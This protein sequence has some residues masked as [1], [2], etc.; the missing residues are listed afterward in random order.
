[1]ASKLTAILVSFGLL[2][3]SSVSAATVNLTSSSVGDSAPPQLNQAT[4]QNGDFFVQRCCGDPIINNATEEYVTWTMD[5]AGAFTGVVESINSATL[6]LQFRTGSDTP[7]N[8]GL[9]VSNGLIASVVS[10][11]GFTQ[12]FRTYD[13]QFDLL[14]LFGEQFLVDLLNGQPTLRFATSNDNFTYGAQLSLSVNLQPSPVPIPASL[15][16]LLSGIFGF[17]ALKRKQR[18]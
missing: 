5:L 6:R 4:Y 7:R 16:L 18:A 14:G 2:F 12:N 3:G 13:T 11:Y 8:D 9:R 15:P 10:P 1:M 17:A